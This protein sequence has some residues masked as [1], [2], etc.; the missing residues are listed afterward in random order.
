MNVK[1]VFAIIFIHCTLTSF[2]QQTT[3]V[4]TIIQGKL[5]QSSNNIGRIDLYN[6]P[7][8]SSSMQFKIDSGTFKIDTQLS[9]IQYFNLILPSTGK[10]N[11][12]YTLE[13][14]NTERMSFFLEP[15]DSISVNVLEDR[16]MRFS[17][18]GA[19]KLNCIWALAKER[20]KLGK[21]NTNIDSTLAYFDRLES[22][23]QEILQRHKKNVSELAYKLI[24]ADI[25]GRVMAGK[26]NAI[27]SLSE[28]DKVSAKKYFQKLKLENKIN[29]NEI[30]LTSA[31]LRSA[32]LTFA[33]LRTSLRYP[34]KVNTGWLVYAYI[35]SKYNG[36]S[37]ALL[38]HD[39]TEGHIK[40]D[41]FDTTIADKVMVD[42]KKIAGNKPEYQSLIMYYQSARKNLVP[43]A[44]A[45]NFTLKDSSG[46]SWKQTDFKGKVVVLDFWF[47][48]CGGCRLL[49]QRMDTTIMLLRDIKEIQFVSISPDAKRNWWIESLQSGDYTSNESINL[50]TGAESYDHPIIKHYQIESYPT[51]I[52][53]DRN[54]NIVESRVP[55]SILF[56]PKDL[57]QKI[58]EVAERPLSKSL[59]EKDSI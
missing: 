8:P 10:Q 6:S 36:R 46:K 1:I 19:T 11:L 2:G 20:L 42:F 32:I 5:P 23:Y 31:V 45:F 48:G 35:K 52:I 44:E 13:R 27:Q 38:L 37:A 40:E 17:G 33:S 43:G 53:I 30:E 12:I 56:T 14:P 4:R 51:L 29:R 21:C 41:T 54:G 7:Y 39:Y 58:R 18:N 50:Y 34:E 28:T 47:S 24:K 3:H 55:N 59:V 49:K 25:N 15:G 26:L 22:G 57:A 9:R 16:E